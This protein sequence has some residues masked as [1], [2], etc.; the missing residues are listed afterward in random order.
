MGVMAA[1]VTETNIVAAVYGPNDPQ[2]VRFR[3]GY[4][5]G[6]RYINPDI[7][8]RGVHLDSYE[9]PVNGASTAAQYIGEGADV[10]F[11]VGGPTG[12]GAI[13]F[14][15]EEGVWV[16][17]VDQDEFMTSFNE[18]ET[19]GG[20]KI[21]SSA[22]K[23]I[24]NAVYAMLEVLVAGDMENFP[25]GGNFLSSAA[26]GGIDFAPQHDA[27]IPEEVHEQVRDVLEMLA[28][29]D[30]ET[31]VDPVSGELLDDMM[32]PAATEEAG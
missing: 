12:T 24:D 15:A 20:D 26:N 28:D 2:V 23:R 22:I 10:V 3:N 18:G 11:G 16:I 17:G 6:A 25:G 32:E 5:Q 4:E 13:T 30:I 1:L 31:G 21:I 8:V 7:E 27:D 14:A 29:G 9:D 19:P